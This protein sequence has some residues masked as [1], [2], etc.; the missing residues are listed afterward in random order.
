MRRLEQLKPSFAK[1]DIHALGHAT[2]KALI[3]PIMDERDADRPAAGPARA[4]QRLLDLVEIGL[5]QSGLH[6]ERGR[7]LGARL[8]AHAAG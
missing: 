6:H 2:H 3:L 4:P 7:G 5:L 8:P 1:A